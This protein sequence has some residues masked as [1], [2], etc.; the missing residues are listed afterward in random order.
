[1]RTANLA[2]ML[3]IIVAGA[4][5][6]QL[7][8]GGYSLAAASG[9]SSRSIVG[10]WALDSLVKNGEDLTSRRVRGGGPVAYY[11]L[12]PDGTFRITLGDSVVETGTWSQDTTT[13]PMIFDHIPDVDGKPGPYY[14]PGIFAISG[15]TLIVT[16]TGPNPER[17]HPTEF[18]SSAAD[19]SWLLVYH[20]APR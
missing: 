3:L 7:P 15:D 4:C 11:T 1:M 16:I 14:V 8:R 10:R 18:H 20:R 12:N 9:T 2:G 17:R 6:G 5:G 19:G 13:S